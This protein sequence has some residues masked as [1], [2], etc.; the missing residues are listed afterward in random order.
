[1]RGGGAY[2][3]YRC[4]EGLHQGLVLAEIECETESE[5]DNLSLSEFAIEDDTDD[6]FI[7][8]GCLAALPKHEFWERLARYLTDSS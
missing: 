2:L 8:G 3:L 4:F 6:P 5:L 7:T 1:M